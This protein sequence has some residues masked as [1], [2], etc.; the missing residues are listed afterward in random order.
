MLSGLATS[1]SW[2]RI[3]LMPTQLIRMVTRL[4]TK[5]SGEAALRSFGP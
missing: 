4:Y 1:N 5:R 3:E 2:W